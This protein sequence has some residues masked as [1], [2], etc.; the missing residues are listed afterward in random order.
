[1]KL[2]KNKQAPTPKYNIGGIIGG[3]VQAVAGIG[4]AIY[5]ARQAKKAGKEM[6][7]ARRKLGGIDPV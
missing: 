4:Q 7:R 2:K 3:G 6:E 1:M 5:G